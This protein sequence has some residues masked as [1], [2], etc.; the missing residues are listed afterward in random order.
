MKIMS[1][2]V[3]GLR[4][5]INKGFYDFI[6]EEKPDILGIQEIKMQEGQAK[7]E[8]LGYKL[9]WNSAERKGYSGTLVY[10]KIEPISVHYGL[11]DGTHNDEGRTITLE[12][13]DFYYV[14]CYVPNSKEGLLRLPYRMEFEDAMR[15][16]LLSLLEKKHVIYCG[17]LNVAHNEIDL[18]NP[19]I[20][21]FDP[22]F[23]DE[24]R[25]KFTELLNSGF[26]DT[27]RHFYPNE[28][29][30]SWWSYR[31]FARERNIGW[32]IDYFLVDKNFINRVVD[33]KI[34]CDVFGSDHCP[35]G[36]IIR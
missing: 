24:E 10:S 16:Y 17:D 14:T 2:N 18:E 19:N 11:I 13:D 12:F 30:Y 5:V 9:Y 6:K 23:S 29:K 32:R 25:N 31:T 28:V 4:S 35:V 36:I 15:A 8:D 33:S 3:N 7:V 22:G 26:I 34:Y 21:H 27:F 20:H 1:F